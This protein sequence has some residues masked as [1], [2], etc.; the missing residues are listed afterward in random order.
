MDNTKPDGGPVHPTPYLENANGDVISYDSPGIS[1]RDHFAGLAMQAAWT[2]NDETYPGPSLTDKEEM[3]KAV[4]LWRNT[5]QVNVAKWAY[6][7][8]DAMIA[9][10]SK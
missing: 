2:G 6:A 5:N 8:A 3:E 10:R 1:I 7:Q 9:E 4:A